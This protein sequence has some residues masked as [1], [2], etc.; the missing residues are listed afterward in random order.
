MSAAVQAIYR[1]LRPLRLYRL[2]QD[3]GVDRELAA[4]EAA[5][6]AAEEALAELERQAFVQ[7][8]GGR[9]LALYEG[10]VG[11]TPRDALGD[12]ARRDLVR[13]R[14]GA[15]PFDFTLAGM[16]N[17]IRAAG[18]EA[19]LTEDVAGEKLTVRCTRVV[20]QSLELDELI[21][22]VRKVLPAHLEVEFDIGD[23][24]WERFE[25]AGVTWNAWDAANMTWGDFDLNGHNLFQE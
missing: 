12:E 9:G 14:L 15:A 4:Y 19:V 24:T 7:T 20:D 21:A 6:A 10:L 2:E 8:A 22:S 16:R 25:A 11:L 13:Y 1:A 23:L 5:F 17:S 18:M 3:S